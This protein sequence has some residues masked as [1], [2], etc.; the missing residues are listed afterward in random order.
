MLM[1]LPTTHQLTT[2]ILQPTRAS[3]RP[4]TLYSVFIAGHICVPAGG[5]EDAVGVLSLALQRRP[6]NLPR[7]GHADRAA[8]SV[9]ADR[10]LCRFRTRLHAF[11]KS[12]IRGSLAALRR[13]QIERHSA[14]C[15]GGPR[16]RWRSQLHIHAVLEDRVGGRPAKA[17]DAVATL[18]YGPRD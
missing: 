3:A 18:A 10:R 17:G 6:I 16:R 14:A 2:L 13:H 15:C 12:V 1:D 11:G 5:G 7:P 4:F 8:L 9:D